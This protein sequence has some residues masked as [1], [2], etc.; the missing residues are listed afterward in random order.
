MKLTTIIKFQATYAIVALGYLF[1]SAYLLSTTGEALSAAPLL[2]SII[3]L[4]VYL[5]CLFL[6]RLERLTW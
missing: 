1:L 6:A 2:P 4:G 5:A 3:M